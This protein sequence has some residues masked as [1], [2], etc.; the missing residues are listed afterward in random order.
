MP[1]P[2]PVKDLPENKESARLD[3]SKDKIDEGG[4]DNAEPSLKAPGAPY[5]LPLI[6]RKEQCLAWAAQVNQG[7]MAASESVL[8]T[9]QAFYD[10]LTSD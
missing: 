6:Y 1:K 7:T 2:E 9:A 10:W 4:E 3:T 8:Q 5:D